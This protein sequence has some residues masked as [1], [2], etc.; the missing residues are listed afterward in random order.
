MS[1]S[2]DAFTRGYLECALFT[3]DPDPS[4]GEW[5]EHD[6]W[7]IENIDPASLKRAIEVCADFQQANRADLN[8]VEDTY[9]VDASRN[10]H[11]FWLTRNG[12]GAG[13]WDRGYGALGDKLTKASKAYGTADVYG[14]D[15]NDQGACDDGAMAAWDGVI[16]IQD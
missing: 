5:S 10:G 16:Y 2:I 7:T 15:T 12:H 11:D 4:S 8:E 13:F 14:P 9:H 3:S 1:V 6:Q